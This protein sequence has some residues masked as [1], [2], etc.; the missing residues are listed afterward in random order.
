MCENYAKRLI[1]VLPYTCTESTIFTEKNLSDHSRTRTRNLR[2]ASLALDLPDHRYSQL[3]CFKT[4]IKMNHK[5][6]LQFKILNEFNKSC[7][8]L[9]KLHPDDSSYRCTVCQQK[10]PETA[11]LNANANFCYGNMA[12]YLMIA[13]IC[14]YVLIFVGRKY[15]LHIIYP[16]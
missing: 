8:N 16:R 15:K 13:M 6:I 12:R 1:D 11:L 7:I 4:H 3:T 14:L 9:Q 5:H 2:I 10:V